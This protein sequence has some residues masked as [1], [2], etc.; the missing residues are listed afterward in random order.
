MPIQNLWRVVSFAGWFLAFIGV[1]F[2]LLVLAA[3]IQAELLSGAFLTLAGLAMA[4]SGEYMLS[5][6]RDKV[7]R[8]V[9]EALSLGG[10]FLLSAGLLW[11][12]MRSAIMNTY[13]GI[14]IVVVSGVVLILVGETMVRLGEPAPEAKK[15][16]GKKRKAVRK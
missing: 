6:H 3:F 7:H 11:L 15:A 1:S 10:I 13:L 4:L 5:L 2:L 14:G 12:V 9:W 8:Y 16:A